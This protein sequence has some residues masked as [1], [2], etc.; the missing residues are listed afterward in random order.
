MPT[1]TKPGAHSR[2][3][4]WVAFLIFAALV[5]GGYVLGWGDDWGWMTIPIYVGALAL[6]IGTVVWLNPR[7]R[8][9]RR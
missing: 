6:L 1:T 2:L 5:L 9:G 7:A 3:A 8:P 4:A